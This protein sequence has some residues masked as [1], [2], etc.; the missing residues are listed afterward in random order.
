MRPT[1]KCECVSGGQRTRELFIVLLTKI[2][3]AAEIIDILVF[4]VH[5]I[6]TVF[7]HSKN[8]DATS[9]E[10]NRLILRLKPLT[11]NLLT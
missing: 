10:L 1:L 3:D 7:D 5:D 8:A 6:F 2:A 4:V 9:V 11:T